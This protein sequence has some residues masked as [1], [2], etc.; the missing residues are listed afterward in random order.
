MESFTHQLRVAAGG[1]F[2][3]AACMLIAL[4]AIGR[5]WPANAND[6]AGVNP[7]TVNIETVNVETSMASSERQ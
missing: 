3:G 4:L 6:T 1:V 2:C 7:E 5:L